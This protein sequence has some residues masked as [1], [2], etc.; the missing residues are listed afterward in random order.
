MLR[1]NRRILFLTVALVLFFP[2]Y[3]CMVIAPISLLTMSFVSTKVPASLWLVF[4]NPMIVVGTFFNYLLASFIDFAL[5]RRLGSE[6]ARMTALLVVI[7]AVSVVPF[8]FRIYGWAGTTG[9]GEWATFP[10]FFRKAVR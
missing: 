9:E 3:G 10:E 7:A 2:L 4:I 5:I 1:P 6:K 8:I